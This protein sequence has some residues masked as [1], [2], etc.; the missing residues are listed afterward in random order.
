MIVDMVRVYEPG[1]TT[2]ML[3]VAGRV[4]G[5]TLE[6]PWLGNKRNV[7]CIPEGVYTCRRYKSKKY[8]DTFEVMNVWGRDNILFHSLNFVHETEGCI[9]IGDKIGYIGQERAI[10]D[11]KSAMGLFMDELKEVEE[12]K[13]RI[14]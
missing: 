4:L 12:F 8:G 9:G 14:R 6:R 5:F 2:G 10:L 13:L 3:I 7:S 11:S 1:V